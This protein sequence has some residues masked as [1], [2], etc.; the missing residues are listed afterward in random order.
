MQQITKI[1]LRLV[2]TNFVLLTLKVLKDS[3]TKSCHAQNDLC[4]N[5]D[6]PLHI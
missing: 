2:E 4:N 1:N 5:N 6:R 3:Q